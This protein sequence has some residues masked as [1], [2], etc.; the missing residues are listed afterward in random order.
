MNQP[1]DIEIDML[2]NRIDSLEVQI[3]WLNSNYADWTN[4]TKNMGQKIM[5]ALDQLV[6]KENKT[7]NEEKVP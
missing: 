5:I 1:V 2:K 7:L 3:R 6:D 4:S